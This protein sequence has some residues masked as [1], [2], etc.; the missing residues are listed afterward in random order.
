MALSK[1]LV[2]RYQNEYKRKFGRDISPKEAEQEIF[3]LKELVR[4]ITKER[5]NHRG[6]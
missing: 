2:H 1:R 4:L 5:R 6:R 3:D